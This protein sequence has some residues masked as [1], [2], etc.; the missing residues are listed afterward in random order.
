MQQLVEVRS[1]L[2]GL[3]PL[4]KVWR[5]PAGLMPLVKVWRLLAG[6]PLQL[7]AGRLQA[8]RGR[9]RPWHNFPAC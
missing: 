2:P 4:V 8:L 3:M 9:E 7:E 6:W 1:L 5:R